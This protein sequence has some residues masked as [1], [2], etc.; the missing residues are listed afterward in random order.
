M[1]VLAEAPGF[2]A[3]ANRYGNN[4]AIM[5]LARR[6]PAVAAALTRRGPSCSEEAT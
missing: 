2:R 3:E 1:R 5:V 4:S 6:Q